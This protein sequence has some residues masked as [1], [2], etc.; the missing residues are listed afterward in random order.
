MD[1][2][3]TTTIGA[4]L[5]F[6]L[7]V[8]VFTAFIIRNTKSRQFEQTL[9]NLKRRLD[10]Q[11]RTIQDQQA[12]LHDH[13]LELQRLKTLFLT[14]PDLAKEF[15]SSLDRTELEETMVRT[16][17]QMFDAQAT[18]FFSAE[19]SHLQLKTHKGLSLDQARQ[20]QQ[21][22]IGTGQIGWVAKKQITM[23]AQ[24]L[25]EESGLVKNKLQQEESGIFS[26]DIC[27]P[28]IHRGRLFGVL[29]VAGISEKKDLAKPLMT[30]I[31]GLGV[32]AMENIF[33]ITEIQKQSDQDS[34]TQLYNANFFYKCLDREIQKADRYQ[35]LISV[36]VFDLDNF[37]SYND[38]HGHHEGDQ[39]LRLIGELIKKDLRTI[40]IPC[41]YGGGQF[42]VILPETSMEQAVFVVDRTRRVIEDY[43]FSLTN[44]I[45]ISGG[46]A[47]YPHQGT[48][49]T[50]L[51]QAAEQALEQAKHSGRNRIVASSNSKKA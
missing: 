9:G 24:D 33:L 3:N 51:L 19:D 22:P 48:T 46:V 38:R 37:K 6:G 39:I 15:N 5:I 45:T 43:R 34:L 28:L 14:F 35:R 2:M 10:L 26:I 47:T 50:A 42:A 36:V 16:V 44:K 20:L 31:A 40:D 18:A 25:K 13:G 4:L 49:T 11:S 32:I 21:L 41:R 12:S 23:T 17:H 8:L 7:S 29:A 1:S 27:A 30:V